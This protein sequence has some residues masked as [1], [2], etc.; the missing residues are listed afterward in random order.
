MIAIQE[1][2]HYPKLFLALA[3]QLL[4]PSARYILVIK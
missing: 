3:S 4:D 2:T 1:F